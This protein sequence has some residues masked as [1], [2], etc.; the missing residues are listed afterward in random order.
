MNFWDYIHGVVAEDLMLCKTK[1]ANQESSK[2]FD[3]ASFTKLH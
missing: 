2:R 3:P 1:M